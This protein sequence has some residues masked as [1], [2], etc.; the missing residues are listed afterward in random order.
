VRGVSGGSAAVVEGQR[1]VLGSENRQFNHPPS[2]AP[3]EAATR[4]NFSLRCPLDDLFLVDFSHRIG[5][6]P[7][8]Y[9]VKTKRFAQ[10][11]HRI[12]RM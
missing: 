11:A 9:G 12:P 2:T 3:R 10:F 5:R 6:L 1:V 4:L 8:R 7:L